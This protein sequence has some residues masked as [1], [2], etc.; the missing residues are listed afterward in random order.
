MIL[1]LSGDGWK[2]T[3]GLWEDRMNNGKK[4]KTLGSSGNRSQVED[5]NLSVLSKIDCI[6]AAGI[7]M[8]QRSLV[9]VLHPQPYDAL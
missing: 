9:A 6:L 1:C 7:D 8:C 3:A 2:L 4:D 5:I